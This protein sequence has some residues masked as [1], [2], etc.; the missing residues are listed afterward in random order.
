MTAGLGRMARRRA[1]TRGVID[2]EK[3]NLCPRFNSR[4]RMLAQGRTWRL[5]AVLPLGVSLDEGEDPGS[6]FG[7]GR[8]V[9]EESVAAARNNEELLG[10]GSC[11]AE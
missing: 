11:G 3:Q 4:E 2:W 9:V 5:V 10:R 1:C 7:S 8:V 6:K